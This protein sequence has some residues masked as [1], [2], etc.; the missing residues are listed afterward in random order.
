MSGVLVLDRKCEFI[1][2]VCPKCGEEI[3]IDEHYNG[4][5]SMC[6]NENCTNYYK[7]I[8]Q[9]HGEFIYT[10]ED[11][12]EYRHTCTCSRDKLKRFAPDADCDEL[13]IYDC[14]TRPILGSRHIVEGS[15]FSYYVCECSKP[16][17]NPCNDDNISCDVDEAHV[18][19][20]A[21]TECIFDLDK[22]LVD[23]RRHYI[24]S[25][26]GKFPIAYKGLYQ[27]ERDSLYGIRYENRTFDEE[28]Y[29]T[30]EDLE[31]K[32]VHHKV[33][34]HGSTRALFKFINLQLLV[35][36]F[37]TT[38]Q[39]GQCMYNLEYNRK[40]SLSFWTIDQVG[41]YLYELKY[42]PT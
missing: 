10:M 28:E 7:P 31:E 6:E 17:K 26:I 39:L 13:H 32:Y 38:E 33:V 42:G 36:P 2:Q 30:K 34:D 16:W 19:I 22:K 29:F 1:G 8:S 4:G 5:Y 9:F 20:D 24:Y 18:E 21:D 35:K 3:G 41:Q 11:K 40:S 27:L 37:L 14:Y 23:L 12:T 25:Q 15:F